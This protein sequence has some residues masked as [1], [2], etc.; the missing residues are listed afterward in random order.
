MLPPDHWRHGVQ[1]VGGAAEHV[2][3][4]GGGLRGGRRRQAASGQRGDGGGDALGT[5]EGGSGGEKRNQLGWPLSGWT[6]NQPA[7][8]RWRQCRP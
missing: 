1:Q 7:S 3:G 4:G 8:D 5:G 2:Q 6:V